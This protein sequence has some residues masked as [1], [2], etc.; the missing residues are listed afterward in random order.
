MS[1]PRQKKYGLVLLASLLVACLGAAAL[2]GQNAALASSTIVVNTTNDELNADADCSLREA[3]IAANTDTAVSG[4][5]AGSG[6]DSIEIAITGI[7][8][9]ATLLPDITSNLNLIGLGYEDF[10]IFSDQTPT[11]K[12]ELLIT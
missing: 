3:I 7:V 9:P 12:V 1:F 11:L 5:P 2:V 10:G 4:C 6:D 8:W